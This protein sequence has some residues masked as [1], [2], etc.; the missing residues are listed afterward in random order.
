VANSLPRVRLVLDP[1]VT[2]CTFCR[3]YHNT[4]GHCAT[5]TKYTWLTFFFFKKKKKEK[6]KTRRTEEFFVLHLFFFSFFHRYFLSPKLLLF[7]FPLARN[8]FKAGVIFPF[9]PHEIQS[10]K[11]PK[12]PP[13]TALPKNYQRNTKKI[14]ESPKLQQSSRWKSNQKKKR[15]KKNQSS[16]I[17]PKQQKPSRPLNHS[18]EIIKPKQE[19]PRIKFKIR[20]VSVSRPDLLH[21]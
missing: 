7:F 19:K 9:L 13:S 10:K 3:V 18:P 5:C 11:S 17:K 20:P 15:K 21:L 14:Q 1:V 2:K 8:F 4:R 12:N 16:A 6:K